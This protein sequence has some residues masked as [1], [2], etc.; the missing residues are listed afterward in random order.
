MNVF[1]LVA[2]NEI[3]RFLIVKPICRHFCK[4]YS[5][6]E[7]HKFWYRSLKFTG[8]DNPF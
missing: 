2:K 6:K 3:M 4:M 1:Y 5:E 8:C 7:K